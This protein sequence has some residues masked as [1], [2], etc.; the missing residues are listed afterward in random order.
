V[1]ANCKA[2]ERE[3]AEN[4][5]IDKR[6][7]QMD[8]ALL[9]ANLMIGVTHFARNEAPAEEWQPYEAEVVK[10]LRELA[11]VSGKLEQ[12]LREIAEH[13]PDCDCTHEDE[14]CCAMAGVFCP[15]CIAAKALAQGEPARTPAETRAEKLIE[16]W[17]E[18]ANGQM[19]TDRAIG[20]DTCA[21]ELEAELN[22]EPARTE[23]K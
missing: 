15:K 9:V 1:Q 7:E 4:V 3:G 21:D 2:A 19:P 20:Y 6:L 23:E 13:N 16:I 18:R 10:R 12:A 17:R 8:G 11:D 14:D 5:E 22:C